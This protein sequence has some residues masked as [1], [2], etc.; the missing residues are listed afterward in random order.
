MRRRKPEPSLSPPWTPSEIAK[1]SMRRSRPPRP[2]GSYYP[3]DSTLSEAAQKL[4][5]KSDEL[6]SASP[7]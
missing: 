1:R 2:R 4:K 3:D 6:K 5:A 7:R